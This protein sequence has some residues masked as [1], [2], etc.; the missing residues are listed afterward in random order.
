MS[1][2]HLAC[3]IAYRR[4]LFDV[5]V[6]DGLAKMRNSKPCSD[7]R[8]ACEMHATKTGPV[9]LRRFERPSR[10]E[11][12]AAQYDGAKAAADYACANAESGFP[13]RYFRLRLQLV[14]NVLAFC[15]GG[16]LLDAGCGP[17]IMVHEL[18]KSRPHDFRITALDQSPAMVESCVAGARDIG[19]VYPAIGQLEAI[20][21]ADV[22]FDVILVTGSL[23]Y[24]N[25]P[26]AIRE[27]S[28]VTRPGGLVVV[29]M[30]NP[31]SPYRLMEWFL[32]WPLLRA[33][34]AIE[35]LLGVPT[36]RRHGVPASG[37]RALTAGRLR[38]LMRQA[39]LQPVGLIYYD[40]TPLVR[41]LGHFP[42]PVRIKDRPVRKSATTRGRGRWLGTAYLV[43]ARRSGAADAPSVR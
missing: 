19:E 10:K 22:S 35:E 33:L 14:Q 20:P 37:I 17:G 28:R 5:P 13:G 38:R 21:F 43:V 4:Y 36:K 25:A 11:A 15:P 7:S 32:Y 23:E 26:V 18:L 6:V 42:R 24:A 40:L 8:E 16:D 1:R 30:L 3:S 12:V 41:L 39:D 9:M 31:L 34:G 29:T 2:G 27:V